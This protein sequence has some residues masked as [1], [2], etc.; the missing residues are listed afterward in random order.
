MIQSRLFVRKTTI[1]VTKLRDFLHNLPVLTVFRSV[2]NVQTG[3]SGVSHGLPSGVPVRPNKISVLKG[4]YVDNPRFQPGVGDHLTRSIAPMGRDVRLLSRPVGACSI[5]IFSRAAYPRIN[6][7][8]IDILSLRDTL[9]AA[10]LQLPPT[11]CP[12]RDMRRSRRDRPTSLRCRINYY[13][14]PQ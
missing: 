12:S 4:R 10:S 11:S 8:V 13:Q 9:N 1:L 7:G 5:K 3:Y 2:C 14:S 6:P